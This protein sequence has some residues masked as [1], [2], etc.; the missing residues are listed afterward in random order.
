MVMETW[1][2]ATVEQDNSL[3]SKVSEIIWQS[4]HFGQMLKSQYLRQGTSAFLKSVQK[5][6]GSSVC[7]RKCIKYIDGTSTKLESKKT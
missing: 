4:R 3:L 6:I 5:H 1:R 7:H 2:P